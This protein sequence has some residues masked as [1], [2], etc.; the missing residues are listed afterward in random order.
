MNVG[1]LHRIGRHLQEAA[2]QAMRDPGDAE[3]SRILDPLWERPEWVGVERAGSSF[4][5]ETVARA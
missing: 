3:L 1:R 4:W 2:F 5:F